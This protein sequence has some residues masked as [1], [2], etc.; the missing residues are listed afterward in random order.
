M[1]KNI[2]FLT[3]LYPTTKMPFF[4]TFVK[5]SYDE[6]S[7]LGWTLSLLSLTEHGTGLFAYI[8]FYWTAFKYLL[9]FKGIVYIHYIS[10]SALPA[11]LARIF[12]GNLIIVLHYHG[13]DAFPEKNEHKIKSFVKDLICK[14][15]NYQ[16]SLVLVPSVYFSKK[17]ASKFHL[18]NVEVSASGGINTSVFFDADARA[19][20]SHI[21]ILFASRMLEEKGCITAAKSAIEIA[22]KEHKA[23]FTFVGNGPKQNEVK[24]ILQPLIDNGTCHLLDSMSQPVLAKQFKLSDIFL[25]PSSRQGESL[26]LVVLEAMACGCIP[27]AYKNGAVPELLGSYA[28]LLT[29]EITE[30][31]EKSILTVLNTE[32]SQIN[33][34]RKTL[35]VTA[36]NYGA[37]NVANA[38]S[39]KLSELKTGI[40]K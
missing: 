4:G 20:N 5:N 32:Q 12:N 28:E 31:F 27:I 8:K 9:Q 40:F 23:R 39:A 2:V 11:I 38:L 25:F 10:H 19:N 15:A 13:S 6:L 3:N 26:G 22:N 30:S 24:K 37:T 33:Q 17:V 34:I 36:Q 14:I 16:S 18:K 29:C 21:E 1:T 7:K 35:I